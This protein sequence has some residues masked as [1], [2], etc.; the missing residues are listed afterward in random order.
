MKLNIDEFEGGLSSVIRPN[1]TILRHIFRWDNTNTCLIRI[2]DICSRTIVIA[3]NIGNIMSTNELLVSQVIQKFKLNIR[4]I[5]W[6]EHQGLFSNS[7]FINE[8]FYQIAF[9]FYADSYT[10]SNKEEIDLETVENLIE[11]EL[12]PVEEWFGL[13]GY[14]QQKKELQ[15]QKEIK[16][17]LQLYLQPHLDFFAERFIQGQKLRQAERGALFYYPEAGLENNQ[18]A[19]WFFSQQ[20]L[21]LQH[22]YH[23]AIALPYLERYNPHNEM[24][25]CVR[26]NDELNIC[27]IFPKPTP[28]AMPEHET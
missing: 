6:I 1:F 14:L 23:R 20:D 17:L 13:D 5:T 15:D 4:H 18:I 21:E 3:S 19:V 24:V 7:S 25:V 11:F 12:E 16:S 28:K 9:S 26:T 22:D 10:I 8:K 27:G 2:Y